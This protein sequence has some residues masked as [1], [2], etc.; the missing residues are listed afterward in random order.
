MIAFQQSNLKINVSTKYTKRPVFTC[1]HC[2]LFD[3]SKHYSFH[4]YYHS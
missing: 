2:S 4:S 1:I 3:L